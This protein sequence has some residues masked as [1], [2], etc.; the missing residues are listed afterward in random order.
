MRRFVYGLLGVCLASSGFAQD[1]PT[2]QR[3]QAASYGLKDA[4]V[5]SMVGW[6]VVLAVASAAA[7]VI[8]KDPDSNSSGYIH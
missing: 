8:F 1:R 6:G 2:I 3:P 4:A 5:L 7:A